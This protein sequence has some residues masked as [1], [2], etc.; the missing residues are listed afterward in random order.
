MNVFLFYLAYFVCKDES[1]TR[2]QC[3]DKHLFDGDLRS[4]NDYR[5]VYCGN[6]PVH[7]HGNDPCRYFHSK[8]IFSTNIFL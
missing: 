5:K 3:P 7:E 6:R 4:C 2:F 1:V 8:K